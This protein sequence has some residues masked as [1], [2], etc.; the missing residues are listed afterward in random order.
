[1]H[2][3]GIEPTLP[4]GAGLQSAHDPYVTNHTLF[5]TI[6]SQRR[7]YRHER[8][9]ASIW[10]SNWV[11]LPGACPCKGRVQPSAN[12][13]ICAILD[14]YVSHRA[15][16]IRTNMVLTLGLEPRITEF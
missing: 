7:F 11:T 1:M 14:F 15:C 5:G 13:E 8:G 16:T 4:E 6:L 9:I 2:D 12:P 3:V 10:W